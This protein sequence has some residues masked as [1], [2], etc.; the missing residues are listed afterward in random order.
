VK[1][2]GKARRN[3]SVPLRCA[4]SIQ[5]SS[6]NNH[7]ITAEAGAISPVRCHIANKQYV[8]YDIFK[9]ISL[10]VKISAYTFVLLLKYDFACRTYTI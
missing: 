10:L 8:K 6:H 2:W 1:A 7:I 9:S 5:I 4:V 3:L